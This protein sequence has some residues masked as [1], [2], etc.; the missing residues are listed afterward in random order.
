MKNYVAILITAF[1]VVITLSSYENGVASKGYDCTGYSISTQTTCGDS[2]SCHYRVTPSNLALSIILN[3]DTGGVVNFYRPNKTY[4][5]TLKGQLASGGTYPVFGL[6]FTAGVAND[7]SFT[8]IGSTLKSI[9]AGT[10]EFIEHK[11]PINTLGG[12]IPFETYFFWIAPPPGAGTITFYYTLLAA[13]NDHTT[14]GDIDKNTSVSYQEMDPT[15]TADLNSNVAVNVYPNPVENDLNLNLS[16]KETGDYGV[17]VFNISGHKIYNQR[18]LLEKHD[19]T[20]KIDA[21]NWSAGMYFVEIT[22]NDSRKTIRII[23][24]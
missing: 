21:V 7:G 11:Q 17:S 18:Y 19:F 5:V 22:K 3:D 23:K 13:N 2:T 24:K 1:L 15:S 6:Q 14:H 12:T 20:T 4:R 16:V 8:L 9:V 10:T